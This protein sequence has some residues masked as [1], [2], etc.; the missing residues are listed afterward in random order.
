[1][2]QNEH[3]KALQDLRS[4]VSET[5]QLCLP[6]IQVRPNWKKDA[7]FSLYRIKFDDLNRLALLKDWMEIGID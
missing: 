6:S 3:R 1:M 7:H 4:N 2:L 5:L